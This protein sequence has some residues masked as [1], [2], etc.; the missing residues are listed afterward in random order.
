MA[1]VRKKLASKFVKES[2]YP[3][4]GA[5]VNSININGFRGI[6]CDLNFEFPVTAITGLNGAGKSTVGQLLLCGHK[7]LSTA[8]YK[9]WYIKDFFP[10]SVADPKPFDDDASVEYRYQTSS[11]NDDRY[12]LLPEPF[13]NGADTRGSQK[14]RQSISGS[15]F[16]SRKLSART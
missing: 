11:P 1:D 4:F 3:N 6:T 9:R 7:K 15:L 13:K 5:C 12:L 14:R 10:V 8:D 16:I 2:R